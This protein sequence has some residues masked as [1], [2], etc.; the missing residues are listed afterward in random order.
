MQTDYYIFCISIWGTNS[1]ILIAT[2]ASWITTEDLFLFVFC[3]I[4]LPSY[5]DA[6]AKPLDQK[7]FFMRHSVKYKNCQ[8][9][10]MDYCNQPFRLQVGEV[11]TTI[12]S[13]FLLRWK[14][15]RSLSTPLHYTHITRSFVS[16]CFILVE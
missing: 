2:K 3:I 8:Y 1:N 6:P 15:S 7:C 5:L 11:V 12:P 13:K 4:K 16:L 10:F 14:E 9:S